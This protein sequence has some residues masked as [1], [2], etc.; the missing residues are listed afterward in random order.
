MRFF[1]A[2]QKANSLA[3]INRQLLQERYGTFY[4]PM[5]RVLQQ[6]RRWYS[7]P[8]TGLHQL[9][10]PKQRH[11]NLIHASHNRPQ[12]DSISI[13]DGKDQ[14]LLMLRLSKRVPDRVDIVKL[15]TSGKLRF[16]NFPDIIYLTMID[17]LIQKRLPP[18]IFTS[19]G[20]GLQ[21]RDL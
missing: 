1:L 11:V 7:S 2:D 13:M 9:A 19:T 6:I 12:I 21:K 4:S 17:G 3:C 18:L 8:T 16:C 15:M 10:I 14:L 20:H 5:V